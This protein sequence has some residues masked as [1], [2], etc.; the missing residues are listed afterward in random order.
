MHRLGGSSPRGSAGPGGRRVWRRPAGGADDPTLADGC[1][2][3]GRASLRRPVHRQVDAVPGGDFQRLCPGSDALASRRVRH[4]W[5]GSYPVHA[6][7]EGSPIV[8]SAKFVVDKADLLDEAEVKPV[9]VLD[10][11]RPRLPTR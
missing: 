1:G 6:S 2:P 11:A 3:L 8:A 4:V 7:A 9:A 5:L 10:A